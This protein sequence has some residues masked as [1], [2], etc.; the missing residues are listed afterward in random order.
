ML[1]RVKKRY[2]PLPKDTPP[3]IVDTKSKKNS[4]KDQP[5][6]PTRGISL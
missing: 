4:K 5:A 3:A 1:R 2:P 6:G